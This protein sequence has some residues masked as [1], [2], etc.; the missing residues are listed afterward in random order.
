M[1]EQKVEQIQ[2]TAVEQLVQAG[3]TSDRLLPHHLTKL[4]ATAVGPK[5]AVIRVEAVYSNNL[6]W[7][8]GEYCS[9]GRNALGACFA[10]IAS[11]AG[12]ECISK[13]VEMFL[14]NV[15]HSIAGTYAVR[16]LHPVEPDVVLEGEVLPPES[17]LMRRGRELLADIARETRAIE[18]IGRH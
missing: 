11:E 12:P 5:Q 17:D 15:E 2:A 14:A 9:E 18:A 13:K 7:V 10:F 4:Y 8:T 1:N 6:V 16:L 3:W